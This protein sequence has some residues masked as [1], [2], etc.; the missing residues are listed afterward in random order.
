VS[1]RLAADYSYLDLSSSNQTERA[2][3]ANDLMDRVIWE[4]SE[5]SSGD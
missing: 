3:A 1:P 4:E 2:Q 5:E